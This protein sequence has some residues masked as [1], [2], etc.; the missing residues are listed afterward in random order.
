ME[1]WLSADRQF[2]IHTSVLLGNSWEPGC[3]CDIAAQLDT[4]YIAYVPVRLCTWACLSQH[5]HLLT[6]SNVDFVHVVGLASENV[7]IR[8]VMP[9]E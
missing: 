1:L 2:A 7:F 3:R 5:V 8:Y 6:L 4:P 9:T